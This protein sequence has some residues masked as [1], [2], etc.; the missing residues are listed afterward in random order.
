MLKKFIF[1]IKVIQHL[2]VF[3]FKKIMLNLRKNIFLN[4][5]TLLLQFSKIL[6]IR[7]V[8]MGRMVKIDRLISVKIIFF[9]INLFN[10]LFV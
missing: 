3:L 9:L 5:N 4:T 2:F 7:D 6:S 1:K 10:R 8:P